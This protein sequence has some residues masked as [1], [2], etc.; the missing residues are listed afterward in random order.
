MLLLKRIEHVTP[1]LDRHHFVD[2]D[3]NSVHVHKS[4]VYHFKDVVG[5][6]LGQFIFRRLFKLYF[7]RKFESTQSLGKEKQLGL[8]SCKVLL[9]SWWNVV[10]SG[11]WMKIETMSLKNALQIFIPFKLFL[12][13]SFE[14]KL[15]SWAW[16]IIGSRKVLF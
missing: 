3:T 4:D 7:S 6:E 11:C 15:T 9:F 14:R 8:R 5:G 16:R 12:R 2:T 13:S 10:S 1:K